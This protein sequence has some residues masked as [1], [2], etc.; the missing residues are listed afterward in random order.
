MGLLAI[1]LRLRKRRSKPNRTGRDSLVREAFHWKPGAFAMQYL[2]RQKPNARPVEDTQAQLVGCR[3]KAI[4]DPLLA[5]M[6]ER[7]TVAL[8]VPL[9]F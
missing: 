3:A 1:S 6:V 9:V 4:L 8:S 5:G 7:T 2:D